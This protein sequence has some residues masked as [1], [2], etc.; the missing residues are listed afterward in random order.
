L[1]ASGLPHAAD[2][3]SRARARIDAQA[4]KWRAA[5]VAACEDTYV[6][7]QHSTELLDR[8][9]AC[10]RDRR[11]EIGA[12]VDSLAAG[13]AAAVDHAIEASAALTP[14][15]ECDADA[16]L[17]D[18]VAPP[19][20]P[21][22]AAEVEAVRDELARIKAVADAGRP[23]EIV[24]AADQALTRA[25]AT[26]YLPLIAEAHLRRGLVREIIGDEADAEIEFVAAWHAA[27]A[28]DHDEIAVRAAGYLPRVLADVVERHPQAMIWQDN[29]TAVARRR[30]LVPGDDLFRLKNLGALDEKAGR[31]ADAVARYRE[32]L[33][34]A[35]AEYGADSSEAGHV[36]EALSL[37]LRLAGDYQGAREHGE[38][39]LASARRTYGDEHPKLA[40][41]LQSLAMILGDLGDEAA[42]EAATREA[43]RLTE[44][45]YG[46]ENPRLAFM[47]NDLAVSTCDHGRWA[48]AEALYRRAIEIR[49][50]ALGRDHQLVTTLL[51]NFA[52]CLLRQDRRDE[53]RALLEEALAT[54]E[55]GLG[56]DHPKVAFPLL[57]LADL[58]IDEGRLDDAERLFRRALEIREASLGVDHPR[59][60]FPLGGLAEVAVERGKL[61]DAIPL[62]ERALEL[63]QRASTEASE[64]ADARFIL[65]RALGDDRSQRARA[66]ELAEEARAGFAAHPEGSA[67]DL[68]KVD[69]WLKGH[70]AIVR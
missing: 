31:Y 12:L 67:R 9:L 17:R 8:R 39:A 38:L 57:G 59:T 40:P 62:A 16:V 14:I 15:R 26:E 53:A 3:W 58:A 60:A 22:I 13:G 1:I 52:T 44:R 18:R 41:V 2:T 56:A 47:L 30:G 21:A 10:L 6:R 37:T 64:L 45:A 49:E 20:D 27:L 35:E 68:E 36:H 65:A 5:S 28:S 66:R 29:A 43:L 11:R 7:H 70:P 42:A 55:E 46:P 25:E 51:Y 48:E 24:D 61:R 34:L 4:T 33:A 23:R 50:S 54:R 69:A 32:A 19:T 63:R